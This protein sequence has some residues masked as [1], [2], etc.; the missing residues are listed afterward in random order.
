MPDPFAESTYS[1]CDTIIVPDEAA[2][3][4]LMWLGEYAGWT[5]YNNWITGPGTWVWVTCGGGGHFI[6][7]DK[8]DEA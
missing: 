2:W 6:Q 4:D 5:E 7:T 1:Y 3:K 8:L